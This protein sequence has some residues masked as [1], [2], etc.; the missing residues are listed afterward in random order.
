MAKLLGVS[1]NT[2]SRALGRRP[3]YIRLSKAQAAEVE[4]LAD[5]ISASAD[6]MCRKLDETIKKIDRVTSPEYIEERARVIAAELA[7]NPIEFDWD[8]VREVL[9]KQAPFGIN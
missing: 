7:A 2:L 1:R 4:Q 6:N 5:Q 3:D 8:A 9:R